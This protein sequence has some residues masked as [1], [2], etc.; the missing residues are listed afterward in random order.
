MTRDRDDNRDGP[1]QERRDLKDEINRAER[2]GWPT[3][4]ATG[5]V[6]AIGVIVALSLSLDACVGR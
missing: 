4:A 1:S 3:L 2:V 5:L 6:I